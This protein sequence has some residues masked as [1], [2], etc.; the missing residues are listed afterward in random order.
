MVTLQ[1]VKAGLKWL[2]ALFIVIIEL[3]DKWNPPVQN[4]NE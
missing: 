2:V 3:I 1:G 4:G